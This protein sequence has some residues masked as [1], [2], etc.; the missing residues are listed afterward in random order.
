MARVLREV[1][2]FFMQ[3]SPVHQAAQAISAELDDLGIPFA[4]AG[5]LAANAHGHRR[6]TEDVGLLLT[7]EGLE[8]FKKAKPGL[9]WVEKF[10]GSKGLRDVRNNVNIAVI[11]TGEFPGDG[12]P[13]PVAF[14]H[15]GEVRELDSEG[16]PFVNLKTLLE[17]KIASGMTAPHRPRDLDDAIRLIQ[18]NQLAQDY[19]EQLHPFVRDK[20]AE[21]WRFAQ[22]SEDY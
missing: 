6:T 13:K 4:I 11:L 18:S 17:L 10:P 1:D 3:R 16:L 15:P 5:A 12:K 2:D 8:E 20:F 14:P 22:I 9:G 21:L 19:A 7:R